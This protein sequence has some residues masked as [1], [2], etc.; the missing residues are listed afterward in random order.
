MKKFDLFIT[1]FIF[2]T[3]RCAEN[4]V[5]G[6]NRIHIFTYFFIYFSGILMYNQL[7]SLPQLYHLR[8]IFSH[9]QLKLFY[10][11]KDFYLFKRFHS[12]PKR[13]VICNFLR[14]KIGNG[15]EKHNI[16]KDFASEAF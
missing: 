2:K 1:S 10:F 9:F 6:L 7:L 5:Y 12:V 15:K 11:L 8:V 13:F 3:L 16:P 14:I 4:I